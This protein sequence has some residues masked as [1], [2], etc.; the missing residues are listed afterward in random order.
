MMGVSFVFSMFFFSLSAPIF[1]A[2]SRA[3]ALCMIASATTAIG[4]YAY[5][6]IR[7]NERSTSIKTNLPFA[8]TNLAAVSGAGVPPAKMFKLIS[9]SKDYGEF[10]LEI[11]KIVQYTELFGYD[12]ITAIR[13]V[14]AVTPCPE[15]KEFFDGLINTIESGGDFTKFLEQ[16]ATESL[17][18]Y[19][20]DRKKYTESVATYSDIY[21]AILI[22]APLFFVAALSLVSLLG[23]NVGNIEVKVLVIVGTYLVIPLLNIA[24]LIFLQVSQPE[25]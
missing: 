10:S 3:F 12:L 22:A 7:A 20:L 19:E 24:F 18:N 4:L 6:F 23:G 8:I 9:E 16:K 1:V 11:L 21:T 5:P 14:S 25:V 13:T 15:L 2:F 17:E